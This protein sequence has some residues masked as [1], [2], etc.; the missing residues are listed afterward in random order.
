VHCN[1]VEHIGFSSAN[2]FQIKEGEKERKKRERKLKREG[3]KE[4]EKK[5]K[6]PLSAW[7]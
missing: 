4:N 1:S 6:K 2:Y 7:V 5:Y 3:V